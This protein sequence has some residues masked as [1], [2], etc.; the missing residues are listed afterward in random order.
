MRSGPCSLR[1]ALAA[2]DLDAHEH[3]RIGPPMRSQIGLF[4]VSTDVGQFRALRDTG[5]LADAL[6]LVRGKPLAD[7]GATAG[8]WIETRRQSSPARS[9][10]S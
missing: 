3:L 5:A 8:V 2:L 9:T 7:L 10:T 1:A 4:E 6:A